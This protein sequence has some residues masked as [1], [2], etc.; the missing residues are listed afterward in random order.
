M[1]RVR[2]RGSATVTGVVLIFAFTSAAV[3]WLARDVDR[4]VSNRSAAQSIAFQAAR[5]GAQAID[6]GDV[7]RGGSAAVRL[8]RHR[9]ADA[10]RRTAKRLFDSY[11][12]DGR[13]ISV[14][15]D[16][17]QVTVTVEIQDMGRVVTGVGSARIEQRA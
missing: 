10:A 12:V 2:D 1:S 8:D 4:S 14:V 9:A 13:V 6:V 16:D 3:I 15:V 17:V 11:A 5:S 7:R